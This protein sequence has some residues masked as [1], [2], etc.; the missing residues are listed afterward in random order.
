MKSLDHPGAAAAVCLAASLAFCGS[1][2][3]QTC[4][5]GP[6][7]GTDATGNQCNTVAD[8]S[9]PR[10]APAIDTPSAT[11]AHAVRSTVA[12]E[13][14]RGTAVADPARS[15][16]PTP[17]VDPAPALGSDPSRWTGARATPPTR[18]PPHAEGARS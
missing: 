9:A 10:P 1:V 17:V 16:Q 5:G 13:G 12:R 3:G 14:Q 7:G 8:A 11:A 2:S 15:P 4:S 18:V 6:D